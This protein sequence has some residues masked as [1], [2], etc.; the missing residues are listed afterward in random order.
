MRSAGV[1]AAGR[2]LSGRVG[3]GGDGSGGAG[4]D[5]DGNDQRHAGCDEDPGDCCSGE[6]VAD[7]AF[8]VHGG[9]REAEHHRADGLTIDDDRFG[10]GVTAWGV[11]GGEAVHAGH[12]RGELV[13]GRSDDGA[14]G[15][16]YDQGGSAAR[17][18]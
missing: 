14:V 4:G 16:Q 1:S 10:D 5:V 3:E 7:V 2:K 18:H 12:H 9:G 17:R 13:G 8:G 15:V 6:G 11:D